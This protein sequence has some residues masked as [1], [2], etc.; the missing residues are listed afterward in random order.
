M[1][2]ETTHVFKLFTKSNNGK[3]AF[4][5]V[6][7]ELYDNSL[8]YYVDLAG[9]VMAD[10]PVLDLGDIKAVE[11]G[12]DTHKGKR[13]IEFEFPYSEDVIHPDYEEIGSFRM[14][15]HK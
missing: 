9:I 14:F 13:G 1:L 2:H 12:G 4:F 15:P 3:V 8:E 6:Y 11:Y 7:T 5:L 10:Y